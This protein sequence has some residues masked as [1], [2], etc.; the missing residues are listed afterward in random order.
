MPHLVELSGKAFSTDTHTQLKAAAHSPPITAEAYMAQAMKAALPTWLESA[1]ATIL[2]ASVLSNH[3]S[4]QI[5]AGFVVFAH[6][7]LKNTYDSVSIAD[8]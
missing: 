4:K 6:R 5:V 7:S 8:L 3:D 2:V 1:R